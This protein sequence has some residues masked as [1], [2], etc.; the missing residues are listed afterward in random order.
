M[1]AVA[2][3]PPASVASVTLARALLLLALGRLAGVVVGLRDLDPEAGLLVEL[4]VPLLA[5][6]A[7]GVGVAAGGDRLLPGHEHRGRVLREAVP[8]AHVLHGL[9]ERLL[10]DEDLVASGDLLPDR[11]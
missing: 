3:L 5:G 9:G 2:L 6:L 1:A 8:L 4:E 10:P 7:R 11:V